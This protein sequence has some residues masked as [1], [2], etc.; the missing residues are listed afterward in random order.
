VFGVERALDVDVLLDT[1]QVMSDAEIECNGS[2][3]ASAILVLVGSGDAVRAAKLVCLRAASLAEDEQSDAVHVTRRKRLGR[4]LDLLIDGLTQSADAAG[5]DGDAAA[6]TRAL[7]GKVR[8]IAARCAQDP[9]PPV[10]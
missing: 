7:I 4:R 1:L 8:E 2:C 5:S 10:S 3:L 6:E 9:E